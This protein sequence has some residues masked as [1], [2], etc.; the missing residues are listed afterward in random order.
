VWCAKPRAL[1][2]IG[3]AA[4]AGLPQLPIDRIASR[5]C[6]DARADRH[7]GACEHPVRAGLARSTAP[8]TRRCSH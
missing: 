2:A 6:R 3:R 4:V 5:R 8:V 7:D 1:R